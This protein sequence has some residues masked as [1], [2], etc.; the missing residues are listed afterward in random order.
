MFPTGCIYMTSCIKDRS[1]ATDMY[2]LF[3]YIYI[4]EKH[5]SYSL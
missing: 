4:E 3:E 1:I 2:F 5:I